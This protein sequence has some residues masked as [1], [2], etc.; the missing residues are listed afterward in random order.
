MTRVSVELVP[1]SRSGLRAEIAFGYHVETGEGRELP[2]PPGAP[3]R[4]Y[5]EAAWREEWRIP[6]SEVCGR[7]DLVALGELVGAAPLLSPKQP[8]RR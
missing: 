3:R 1:R 7:P 2:D 8:Y 4:W 5:A 6:D